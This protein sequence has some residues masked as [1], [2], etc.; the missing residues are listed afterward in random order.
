MFGISKLH[1]RLLLE[2]Q[3]TFG[4]L[5]SIL[6]SK[7]LRELHCFLPVG[8][9]FFGSVTVKFISDLV[10][11]PGGAA[12]AKGRSVM[13]LLREGVPKFVKIYVHVHLKS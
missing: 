8:G 11:L 4:V 12:R 2:P 1:L 9:P 7:S 5:A 13:Y 3:K 6:P 10:Y